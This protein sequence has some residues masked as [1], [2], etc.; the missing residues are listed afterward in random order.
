[1]P[2]D[3]NSVKELAVSVIERA[4]SDMRA[5]DVEALEWLASTKASKWFDVLN[6]PQCAFLSRTD[7]AERAA[8]LIEHSIIDETSIAID[9]YK[10]L[11]SVNSVRVLEYPE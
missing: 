11:E 5:G 1:M 7:W 8:G 10:Y 3:L 2:E 4:Q 6:I 9:A